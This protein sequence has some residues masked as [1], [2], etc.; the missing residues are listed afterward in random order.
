VFK[1][2]ADPLRPW[3]YF[4]GL[5]HGWNWFDFIIVMLCMP[6]L[7][8]QSFASGLR[9]FRL[10]RVLKI[11]S[12]I[13]ELLMILTGLIAGCKSA[14]WILILMFLFFY[15]YATAGLMFFKES[16][17][18]HFNDFGAA[19]T[20]LYQIASLDDWTD[21]MYH[22][23][24]GCR[25]Y[26][27]GGGTS[28]TFDRN[29]TTIYSLGDESGRPTQSLCKDAP[30]P[31]T[32]Y[33]FFFTFVIIAAIIIIQMFVGAVAIAMIDV[34]QD[35]AESKQAHRQEHQR[36]TKIA[37]LDQYNKDAAKLPLAHRM[38]F[39]EVS[40]AFKLGFALGEDDG[41][42]AFKNGELKRFNGHPWK[43]KYMR[44]ALATRAFSHT[45]LFQN[46]IATV[47]VIAGI[48][49]GMQTDNVMQENAIVE[50]LI[51]WI[52][53][54]ELVVKMVG[55]AFEPVR[56]FDDSWNKF[57]FFIVFMS[58]MPVGDA[59]VILRLLRLLR[60]LKLLRVFPQLTLLVSALLNSFSSLGY[61]G[62]LLFIFFY[63]F[64]IV[65]I[66]AFGQNDPFNFGN[67][68]LAMFALLRVATFEKWKDVMAINERGCM[69]A[70]SFPYDTWEGT[71]DASLTV[72]HEG[73]GWFSV[74]YFVIFTIVG[75]LILLSLFIGIIAAEME[76]ALE[77]QKNGVKFAKFARDQCE[78][79]GL[80]EACPAF[81][82]IFDLMDGITPSA[83]L[84]RLELV[85]MLT[86]CDYGFDPDDAADYTAFANAF[87]L[88]DRD[89]SEEL[90]L[91]EFT[92]FMLSLRRHCPWK[93]VGGSLKKSQSFRLSS[94]KAAEEVECRMRAKELQLAVLG[95]ESPVGKQ[96][97][98]NPKSISLEVTRKRSQNAS[99][100]EVLTWR[101]LDVIG[102]ARLREF[103]RSHFPQG[104]L[105]QYERWC[106]RCL[107]LVEHHKFSNFM[108]SII[109]LAGLLVGLQV[110]YN[111][112]G[113]ILTILD[114]IVFYCFLLEVVAK[115]MAYEYAPWIY[116]TCVKKYWNFF[117][118]WIVVLSFPGV[119]GGA[120]SIL[121][122]LRL[123]R[124]VKIIDK[125]PKLKVI[126][127][128]L[129]VGLMSGLWICLLMG[130]VFYIYAVL[131]VSMFAKNDPWHFR[132]MA[133]ALETLYIIATGEDWTDVFYINAYGCAYYTAE[134]M[135][136]D[137]TG[138]NQTHTAANWEESTVPGSPRW[139]SL[140][141]AGES[142]LFACEH[143]EMPI[144][145]S[146]FFVSFVFIATLILLS[147]FVGAI[148]I[149]I[150]EAVEKIAE[151]NKKH[152]KQA[153]IDKKKKAYAE[154]D[155]PDEITRRQVIVKSILKAWAEYGKDAETDAARKQ[156]STRHLKLMH[157]TKSSRHIDLSQSLETPTAPGHTPQGKPSTE[158]EHEGS[159]PELRRRSDSNA[160]ALAS[161][162]VAFGGLREALVG[163][164]DGLE[165]EGSEP[166]DGT[167]TAVKAAA[168]KVFAG[169]DSKGGKEDADEARKDSAGAAAPGTGVGNGK[170]SGGSNVRAA[171]NPR[172][173]AAAQRR[174]ALAQAQEVRAQTAAAAAAATAAAV[175]AAG[176]A[177]AL[178]ALTAAALAPLPRRRGSSDAGGLFSSTENLFPLGTPAKGSLSDLRQ[179]VEPP[180]V[181]TEGLLE[182]SDIETV[183][184]TA[185]ETLEE[186][187]A[188]IDKELSREL[189]TLMLKWRRG[190]FS[191]ENRDAFGALA[192]KQTQHMHAACVADHQP[193]HERAEH[194]RVVVMIDPLEDLI[195]LRDDN[196]TGWRQKYFRLSNRM[197]IIRDDPNFQHLINFF[198]LVASVMVGL[199]AASL[200][201]YRSY[202]SIAPF[203][204][205]LDALG[206]FISAL[207]LVE[208]LVKMFAECFKPLHFFNN[209]WNVLDFI[210]VVSSYLPDVGSL[211]LL[212][213]MIR[214]LRVLK[215]L[216]V[217]PQLRLLVAAL[218]NS[219]ASINYVAIIMFLV[220]YIFAIF[221]IMLFKVRVRARVVL[222]PCDCA[223][224][225]A[226]PTNW[227]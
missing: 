107:W 106:D 148:L 55:E 132:S 116:F 202:G 184:E 35:M 145:A 49:V 137:M 123:A 204:M 24:Y 21:I 58:F 134:G 16:D 56:Y 176:A 177:A 195:Q 113:D 225:H 18:R 31:I 34:M 193:G 205:D 95:A 38:R 20:S 44:V 179:T 212:F 96:A 67:V 147:L 187:S 174:A 201:E 166:P 172:V 87:D 30:S 12:K 183:E 173:A 36:D 119:L 81:K 9:L 77:G 78:L 1:I 139:E 5:N 40:R 226:V 219:F 214:L 129:C 140:H 23:Y 199:E 17:P 104:C 93:K 216:R 196:M 3:V 53:V 221:A 208:V 227:R 153:K 188:R 125:V 209:S 90:D 8:F 158:E 164:K 218:V 161:P 155:D 136:V 117:D 175:S 150:M 215:V 74:V 13:P 185:E 165:W 223:I 99:T 64:G 191:L 61:I 181:N 15:M 80:P 39:D 146:V 154:H 97:I 135:Y 43:Q 85:H 122:L 22:N 180:R 220:F 124:V 50:N 33:I 207:F 65:G 114:D 112:E 41:G 163:A 92:E 149:A 197:I 57:D 162:P 69:R 190:A 211:S 73:M 10:M 25:A 75:S 168:A 109:L 83:T 70:L 210:I 19:F 102:Q 63:I 203:N 91:G 79:A 141:P 28:Y 152:K 217:F 157:L 192:A 82:R 72:A 48:M 160:A 27:D 126:V 59:A 130:I 52:F 189:D 89:C 32:A 84:D 29:E 4:T 11:M 14:I 76:S 26:P 128:G 121:R 120:G 156:I 222:R 186:E 182:Q 206:A 198:I 144:I 42:E 2:W 224:A 51:V 213:R 194:E 46:T 131:G 37:V 71:C 105:D 103:C 111:L 171:L 178:A 62:L 98:Y 115:M 133:Y 110:G 151:D 45:G 6:F 200:P 159:P 54:A 169:A 100:D 94:R 170:D 101:H 138:D 68:H 142:P 86:V 60:V 88:V 66:I 7:P 143:S 108:L 118:F 167:G 47:I 127:S